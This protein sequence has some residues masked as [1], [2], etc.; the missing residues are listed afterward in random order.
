MQ[1]IETLDG[2]LLVPRVE[3]LDESLTKCLPA[4][5]I[6]EYLDYAMKVT[7][8]PPRK[9][10]A[11]AVVLDMVADRYAREH[12]SQV[13]EARLGT[14][15]EWPTYWGLDMAVQDAFTVLQYT[16][17]Y[18]PEPPQWPLRRAKATLREKGIWVKSSQVK[19]LLEVAR[20]VFTL[21]EWVGHFSEMAAPRH[22]EEL[23]SYLVDSPDFLT[24]LAECSEA[25]RAKLEV[26]NTFPVSDTFFLICSSAGVET[27]PWSQPFWVFRKRAVCDEEWD[28]LAVDAAVEA[29]DLGSG[30]LVCGT[31]GWQ[32]TVLQYAFCN[33]PHHEHEGH[34]SATFR[35]IDL[36][37]GVA[38]PFY[39]GRVSVPGIELDFENCRVFSVEEKLFVLANSRRHPAEK[40]NLSFTHMCGFELRKVNFE[41]LVVPIAR[42]MQWAK[43]NVLNVTSVV[44]KPESSCTMR[45]G[46]G[47]DVVDEM[48]AGGPV[49]ARPTARWNGPERAI[50]I[51]HAR[52]GMFRDKLQI[53]E[54]DADGLHHCSTLF[55]AGD[56]PVDETTVVLGRRHFCTVLSFHN[57]L[58]MSA[59]NP[60]QAPV[61]ASLAAYR[62]DGDFVYT[63]SA[64]C[65]AFT[66]V[67]C[68]K[69]M[70]TSEPARHRLFFFDPSDFA[71]FKE[72]KKES[73]FETLRGVSEMPLPFVDPS[74]RCDL[75]LVPHIAENSS[76]S[77]AFD[78]W[79]EACAY[80][81]RFTA[82]DTT[83]YRR[84]TWTWS[85]P[86]RHF[87]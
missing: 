37:T 81:L 52:R 22:L 69:D 40:C 46:E 68:D 4:K 27:P 25:T 48:W 17:H 65:Q 36:D 87:Y 80:F 55:D 67:T 54:E 47:V 29:P 32:R 11:E 19:K 61:R 39:Q 28:L 18:G 13:I 62:E 35:K 75:R 51:T 83:M 30:P 64:S 73:D 16:S 10:R 44:S 42:H 63:R 5:V 76:R 53:L 9:N 56:Y 1:S 15:C 74:G 86:G 71:T 59:P 58:A 23:E 31:L 38:G 79:R 45:E 3:F 72:V 26:S 21:D 82:P 60:S 20:D 84:K 50:Y 24:L 43:F 8:V 85:G 57:H 12:P 14:L 78:P 41:H 70:D 66:V 34:A 49:L 7:D 2:S 33:G 77:Y 6:T